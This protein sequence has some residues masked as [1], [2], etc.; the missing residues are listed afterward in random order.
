MRVRVKNNM[1]RLR[2]EKG[3][4]QKT[5]ADKIGYSRETISR[6]ETS[7]VKRPNYDVLKMVAKELETTI[8]ELEEK[9]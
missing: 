7:I 8:E 4:T 3:Y 6:Y 9:E 2:K 5:L 1:A